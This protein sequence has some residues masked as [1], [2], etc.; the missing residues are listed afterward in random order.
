MNLSKILIIF[1]LQLMIIFVYPF[2][3]GLAANEEEILIKT[4]PDKVFF[5]LT[6]MAPGR[7]ANKTLTIQNRGKLDFTYTTEVKFAEGS[8][9][10]FNEYLLKI[11]DARGNLVFD[12]KL[13][14]FKKLNPRFLKSMHQ[15]DLLFHLMFPENLGNEFQGLGCKLVFIFTAKENQAAPDQQPNPNPGTTG[16]GSP[17]GTQGPGDKDTIK[18]IRP[19]TNKDLGTEAG[20]GQILPSTASNLYNY[21]LAG[22]IMAV[23]GLAL[24]IIQRRKNLL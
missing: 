6:N 21:L 15:E 19:I 13:K 18:P 7:Q 23:T 3:S 8:E 24:L 20:E 17:S 22:F 9:K 12:G 1:L 2:N 10:L 11:S 5:N 16:P 14:D 4:D